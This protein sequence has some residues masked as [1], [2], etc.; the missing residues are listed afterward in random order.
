M[1]WPQ[2]AASTGR[3]SVWTMTPP[4]P[5]PNCWKWRLSLSSTRPPPGMI[6][7]PAVVFVA[8]NARACGLL[9]L[10]VDPH[11]APQ[12]LDPVHGQAGGLALAEPEAGPDDDGHPEA[13]RPASWRAMTSS[14]DSPGWHSP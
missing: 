3:P 5:A 9:P 8:A 14:C 2:R 6:R 13:R 7:V 10:A 11:G 1:Q 4:S 12:E